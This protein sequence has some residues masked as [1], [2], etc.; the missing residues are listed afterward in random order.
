[1]ETSKT[2]QAVESLPREIVDARPGRRIVAPPPSLPEA[3]RRRFAER[4][5]SLRAAT[6]ATEA[7]C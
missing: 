7:A 6:G 3:D 4:V 2:R 1:M 5:E